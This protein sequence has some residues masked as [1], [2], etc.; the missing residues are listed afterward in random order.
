MSSQIRLVA[1]SNM[2]IGFDG[3][4]FIH[5]V[6][7]P[8]SSTIVI[9]AKS[10]NNYDHNFHVAVAQYY[11]HSVLVVSDIGDGKFMKAEGDIDDKVHRLAS[12]ISEF[13]ELHDS[14][15][16]QGIHFFCRLR[17]IGRGSAL[18]DFGGNGKNANMSKTDIV[19]ASTRMGIQYKTRSLGCEHYLELKII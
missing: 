10:Q 7:M 6:F 17:M 16:A 3:A 1:T 9:F 19:N 12:V 15:Y 14:A 18:S 13:V 5:Q 8:K 11:Q 2:L 4:G